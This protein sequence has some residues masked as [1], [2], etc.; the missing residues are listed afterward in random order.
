MRINTIITRS[1]SLTFS[2]GGTKSSINIH[3][4]FFLYN[5]NHSAIIFFLSSILKRSL[6]TTGYD[7]INIMAIT[8]IYDEK[9]AEKARRAFIAI[10]VS[11]NASHIEYRTVDCK[12]VID[13]INKCVNELLMINSYITIWS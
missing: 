4:I 10:Y 5:R 12:T 2:P 11:P 6:F 13:V 3:D 9:M 8:K 7:V 1:S